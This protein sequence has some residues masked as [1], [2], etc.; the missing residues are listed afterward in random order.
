M[1]PKV[2]YCIKCDSSI[3]ALKTYIRIIA[4][5]KKIKIP[6]NDV[7][8]LAYFMAEGFNEATKSKIVDIGVLKDQ[9]CVRNSLTRIR[10]SGWVLKNTQKPY[11][12]ILCKE[13]QIP[14][15]DVILVN[16]LIDNR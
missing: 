11:G 13:L 10:R 9:Q 16:I 2:Q 3:E 14:V 15:S 1:R 12:E 7:L 4:L 8:I 5:C 6:D